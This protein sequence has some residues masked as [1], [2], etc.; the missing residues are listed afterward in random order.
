MRKGKEQNESTAH[1]EVLI[2]RLCRLLKKLVMQ[3]A[4]YLLLERPQYIE[5]TLHQLLSTQVLC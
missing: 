5:T 1:E 3:S 4:L 2:E